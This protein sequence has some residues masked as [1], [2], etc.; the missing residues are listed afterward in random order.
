[1][2]FLKDFYLFYIKDED[3]GEFV[4]T[5]L[6]IIDFNKRVAELDKAYEKL[7]R[8]TSRYPSISISSSENQSE[9]SVSKNQIPN[10]SSQNN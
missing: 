7:V 10:K 9:Q 2:K 5:E 6:K 1:M 3:S 8:E 4:K